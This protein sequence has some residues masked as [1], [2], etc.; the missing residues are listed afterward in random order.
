[1]ADGQIPRTLNAH[2]APDADHWVEARTEG[3]QK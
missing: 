2:G 3:G 1:M